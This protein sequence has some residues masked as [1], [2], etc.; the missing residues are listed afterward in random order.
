MGFIFSKKATNDGDK[1]SEAFVDLHSEDVIARREIYTN[2]SNALEQRLVALRK[3]G[4]YGYT[5]LFFF[6]FF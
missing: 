6:F 2:R 1:G 3:I 5:G 4:L